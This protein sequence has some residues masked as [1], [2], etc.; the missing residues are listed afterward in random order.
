MTGLFDKSAAVTRL[1]VSVNAAVPCALQSYA[2]SGGMQGFKRDAVVTQWAAYVAYGADIAVGDRM[3][4]DSLAYRV[5][6]VTPNPGGRQHHMKIGLMKMAMWETSA[7]IGGAATT[8]YFDMTSSKREDQ[9]NGRKIRRTATVGINSPGVAVGTKVTCAGDVWTLTEVT[10]SYTD[11]TVGI[12]EH[13]ASE[14][15]L[16]AREVYQ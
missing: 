5:N 6:E 3:T 4:I 2:D 10:H 16:R 12:L 9:A 15:H 13:L 8:I 14:E 1:G 7:T 11:I